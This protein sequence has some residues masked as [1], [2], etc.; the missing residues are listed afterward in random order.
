MPSKVPEGRTASERW[1][2]WLNDDERAYV[3]TVL[4]DDLQ[5]CHRHGAVDHLQ[6]LRRALCTA[7]DVLNEAAK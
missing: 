2:N 4:E 1:R 7:M 6:R 3:K 5:K